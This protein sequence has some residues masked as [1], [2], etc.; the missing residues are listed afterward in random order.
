MILP[1]LRLQAQIGR[2]DG[3]HAGHERR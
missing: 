3:Q 2:R 1:E